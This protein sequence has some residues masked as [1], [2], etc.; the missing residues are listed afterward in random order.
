[1]HIN[2]SSKYNLAEREG[3]E[4]SIPC[5]IP[6]FQGGALGHYATSPVLILFLIDRYS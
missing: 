2:Y 5:G 6:P 1:M 3:F 4:P